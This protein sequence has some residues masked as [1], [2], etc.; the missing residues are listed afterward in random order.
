MDLGGVVEVY[1]SERAII[2]ADVGDTI[3]RFPQRTFEQSG[4]LPLG[5]VRRQLGYE[6]GGDIPSWRDCPHLVGLQRLRPPRLAEEFEQLGTAGVI[7]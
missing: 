2:R 7:R 3:I 4:P 6:P 5:N 1:P